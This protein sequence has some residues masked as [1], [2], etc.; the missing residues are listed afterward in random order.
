MTDE[1]L[2]ALEI[3]WYG[4]LRVLRPTWPEE[5][6]RTTAMKN[7]SNGA[8]VPSLGALQK[9]VVESFRLSWLDKIRLAPGVGVIK[10]KVIPVFESVFGGNWRTTAA[11]I[12]VASGLYFQQ[13]GVS[14]PTTWPEAQS[15][16]IGVGII[17]WGLMQKDRA[18]GSQPGDPPTK[19]H[20]IGEIQ[21]GNDVAPEDIQK[22][23]E[24]TRIIDDL[25][26]HTPTGI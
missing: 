25:A 21:R 19:E 13:N 3:A 9:E 4:H 7:A 16:G 22:A 12:A 1:E 6:V 20:L 14:F 10:G 8:L 23:A 11:S 15:A 2:I 26:G 24:A 17:W 18:T 5:W